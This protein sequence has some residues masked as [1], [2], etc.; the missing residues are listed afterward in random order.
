MVQSFTL[1]IPADPRFH[2]MASDVAG[3]LAEMSGGVAADASAAVAQALAA[4]ASGAA[5]A[6]HIELKFRRA[7]KS[8]SVDL[9]SGS[10]S[11]TVTCPL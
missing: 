9:R 7:E 4:I 1:V 11:E 6:D 5:A 2:P 3:R 10:R 8:V